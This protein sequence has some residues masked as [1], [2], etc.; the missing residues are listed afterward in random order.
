M[1]IKIIALAYII[2]LLFQNN[3]LVYAV[4]ILA[5]VKKHFNKLHFTVSR[6]SSGFT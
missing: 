3:T 2:F 6:F 1:I 4:K 5:F